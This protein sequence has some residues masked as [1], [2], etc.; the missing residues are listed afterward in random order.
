MSVFV[1]CMYAQ[2]GRFEKSLCLI[3]LVSSLLVVFSSP[4][5]VSLKM[6][7]NFY[8]LV[9]GPCLFLLEHL[10]CLSNH[11]THW[12]MSVD[13]VGLQI[14]NFGISN[15]VLTLT[16]FFPWCTPKSSRDEF[17][18]QSHILQG[19]RTTSWSNTRRKLVHYNRPLWLG[20]CDSC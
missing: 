1:F 8:F 9:M 13:N 4:K 15:S 19:L 10:F 7:Y 17:S 5:N 6:N 12:T 3:I 11:K 16:Y 14:C 20:H 18:S 2:K